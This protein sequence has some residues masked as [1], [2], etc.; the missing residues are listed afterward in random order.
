MSKKYRFAGIDVSAGKLDVV[1]DNSRGAEMHKVFEN[2]PK[3]HAAVC[4][5]I[6]PGKTPA[7]VVLEATGKYGVDLAL[8]LVEQDI[9]V[10]VIN[11]LAARRYMQFRMRRGKTDKVDATLLKDIAGSKEF[12]RWTPPASAVLELRNIVRRVRGV[13]KQMV[14]DKN[15]LH[16]ARATATTPDYILEDM[17]DAIATHKKRIAGL[18]KHA[19]AVVEAS[20]ELQDRFDAFQSLS[21][22]GA[23]TSLMLLGEL[24]GLDRS[25]STRQVVAYAGLDPRPTQSGTRDPARRISK[26]GN[27]HLRSSLYMPAL[28]AIRHE[29]VVKAHYEAVL[30]RSGVKKVAIV[31]VMRKLLHTAW[32]MVKSPAAFDPEKYSPKY[33]QLIEKSEKA[34]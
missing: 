7:R 34:A 18:L 30:E 24:Y 9:E 25:L 33:A 12:A 20:Q 31:A 21:G 17:L 16:A 22:F 26:L 3:G 29:P 4:R 14:S 23:P 15:Q 8:A 32:G 6:R 11:P 2:N 28:T 19:K 5:F 13:T 27:A 1:I 10:C